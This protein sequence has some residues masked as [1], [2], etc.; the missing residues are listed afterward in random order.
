MKQVYKFLLFLIF[1]IF[2]SSCENNEMQ[3]ENFRNSIVDWNFLVYM[4]ADNNLERFAIQNIYDMK[5]I[6][7]SEKI[8]V[9]VLLDR[10]PGYD[11]SNGNWSGTRLFHIKK[12]SKNVNDDMILDFGE[13]DM[14]DYLNLEEFITYANNNFPSKRTVL[15]IWSHG[16]GV[17]QDGLIFNDKDKMENARTVIQDYSTSYSAGMRIQDFS[18]AVKNAEITANKKID[19]VYFDACF[20]QM[21]EICWQLKDLTNFIVASQS[22]VPGTGGNYEAILKYIEDN[23]DIESLSIALTIAERFYS[24]YQN[25]LLSSA[26]S[27]V[28]TESLKDGIDHFKNWMT[29]LQNA[30]ENQCEELIKIR[31]NAFAYSSTYKEFIDLYSFCLNIVNSSKTSESVKS[32]TLE[33]IESLKNIIKV[34][35]VTNEYKNNLY[36]LSLNFPIENEG[37]QFYITKDMHYDVFDIYKETELGDFIIKIND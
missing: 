16:N 37:L 8:N 22:E 31:K 27:V 13:L 2:F 35:K 12:N 23:E 18:K 11:K 17:F 25:S 32:K 7:S 14:T 30:D 34:N 26:C 33:L 9:L 10:S 3:T 29:T 6:G 20:M 4:G 24:K 5:K 21:M 15:V 28:S 1:I 19:I 36:G